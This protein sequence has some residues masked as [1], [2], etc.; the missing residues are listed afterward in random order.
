MKVTVKENKVDEIDFS[1][2]GQILIYN[3]SI[4]VTTGKHSEDEFEAFCI[5]LKDKSDRGLFKT[6][7]DWNKSVFR[8]FNGTITIEQ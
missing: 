4:V 7:Y 8:K 6:T 2:K 1:V 5:S 3:K